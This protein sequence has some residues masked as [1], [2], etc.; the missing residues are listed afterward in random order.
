MGLSHTPVV[1]ANKHVPPLTNLG[2]KMK[3]YNGQNHMN[4]PEGAD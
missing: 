1:A 4:S 3:D 2:S